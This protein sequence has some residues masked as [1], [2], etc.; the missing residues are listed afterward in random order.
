VHEE[1]SDALFDEINN[2]L[3]ANTL[4]AKRLPKFLLGPQIYFRIYAERHHVKTD[5]HQIRLLALTGLK[6]M[7]A[8]VLYW[9]IQLPPGDSAKML[10]EMYERSQDT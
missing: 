9:L 6:K 5:I 8:P 4:L 10:R 1:L 7:Y 2:V 3:D